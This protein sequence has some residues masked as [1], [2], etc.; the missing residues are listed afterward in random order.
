[1]YEFL[2]GPLLWIS[3]VICVA[4]LAY[5]TVRLFRLTEKKG[6]AVCPVTSRKDGPASSISA[7]E[8]KLDRIARFQNSVLGRHP[9]MAVASTLFH[10]CLFVPPLFLMAH[11]T[12]LRHSLG[13]R[14]PSI[15]D[16]LADFMTLVVLAGGIFFLVR[17][18]AIPKVSAISSRDDYGVLFLTV[19]PY[20]TGFL[21][22]HHLFDY[23]TMLTMH[24]L[25]GDLLL[26][27]L[28]F[29]KV[30]HMVFFFF[31]R[32]ALGGDSGLGRGNRTWSA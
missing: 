17:R 21:A 1:M 25:T 18:L 16:G 4:G 12:L 5:R 27:A 20:L 32:L 8:I 22:Y 19:A 9:V 2:K 6:A 24:A 14:L 30:G 7:E 29:T 3:A 23:K 11:N 13:L 26:I 10:L 28:P 31:S 15:P